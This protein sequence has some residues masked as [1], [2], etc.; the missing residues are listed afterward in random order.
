VASEWRLVCMHSRTRPWSYCSKMRVPAAT[1]GK[2]QDGQGS[3]RIRLARERLVNGQ[4]LG[5][6]RSASRRVPQRHQQAVAA[7]YRQA[8]LS[9]HPGGGAMGTRPTMP[10]SGA[11]ERPNSDMSRTTAQMARVE[12]RS[13]CRIDENDPWELRWQSATVIATRDTQA[14]SS[15]HAAPCKRA[16]I[17]SSGSRG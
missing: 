17:A 1:S 13:H 5:R 2:A 4:S 7:R 12:I 6:H 14:R 16:A 9:S 15:W 11:A 8:P 10:G 3:R